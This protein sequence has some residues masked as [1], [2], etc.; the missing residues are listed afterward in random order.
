M[1][2]EISSSPYQ[3]GPTPE[4]LRSGK[5]T[6]LILNLSNVGF[7]SSSDLAH[8]RCIFELAVQLKISVSFIRPI[9]K[10]KESY[11]GRMGL[12]E[13]TEYHY[14]LK[15][16]DSDNF[17]ALRKIKNQNNESLYTDLVRV[18]EPSG[19]SLQQIQ[20]LSEALLELV[21]NIH[22]HS[23]PNYMQGWGFVHSQALRGNSPGIW[24]GIVDVGV[25]FYGSYLRTGQLRGRTEAQIVLDSL[26]EGQTSLTGDLG[27]GR[28]IGLGEVRQFVNDYEGLFTIRTGRTGLIVR[29]QGVK[30]IDLGYPVNGTWIELKVP[31]L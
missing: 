13:G 5:I 24:V 12:F 23:G 8:L 14:P 30:V 20:S 16:H 9:D 10:N 18:F 27:K 4:K 19:V 21:N 26:E 22:F 3:L 15:K 31:K 28:G 25:G 6:E 17:L 7:I 11:L 2:L 1:R 29:K